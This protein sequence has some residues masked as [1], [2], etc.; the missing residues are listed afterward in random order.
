MSLQS[1]ADAVLHGAVG[2]GDV[3]GV[4][5]AATDRAGTIYEGGFGERVIGSGVP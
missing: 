5:A 3:P 2:N 1:K 4:V